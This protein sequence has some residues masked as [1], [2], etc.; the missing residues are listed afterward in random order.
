[1][2]CL[3]M[4]GWRAAYLPNLR[5]LLEKLDQGHGSISPSMAQVSLSLGTEQKI[6]DL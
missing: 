2:K 3:T 1:M 5:A 6:H 4:T